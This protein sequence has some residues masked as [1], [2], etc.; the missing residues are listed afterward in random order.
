ML[1]SN[2]PGQSQSLRL[3]CQSSLYRWTFVI[4][5]KRWDLMASLFSGGSV[6]K[7]HLPL[8]FSSSENPWQTRLDNS[9]QQ[10]WEKPRISQGT[11]R[12]TPSPF[13]NSY[14][15]LVSVTQRVGYSLTA[16]CLPSPFLWQHASIGLRDPS[17]LA[18]GSTKLTEDHPSKVSACFGTI[19][20][21]RCATFK[22]TLLR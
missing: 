19:N 12:A 5:R 17:P 16:L 14:A 22:G 8:I 11:A 13:V 7:K 2:D 15:N 4:H 20:I 6:S 3:A 10:G 18:G 21:R 1:Q 9:I